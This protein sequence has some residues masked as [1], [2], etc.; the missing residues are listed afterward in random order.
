M[1]HRTFINQNNIKS[2]KKRR[3]SESNIS[4][5]TQMKIH[6]VSLINLPSQ[7][8]WK[9]QMNLWHEKKQARDHQ[10][11]INETRGP[12]KTTKVSL[13]QSKISVRNQ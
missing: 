12:P 1:P 8:K 4:T 5:T 11:T 7:T 10:P 6:I 9:H 3:F 13:L 2:L